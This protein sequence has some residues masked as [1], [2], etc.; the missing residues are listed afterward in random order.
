MQ[1]VVCCEIPVVT[2]GGGGCAGAPACNNNLDEDSTLHNAITN[3]NA[4][5]LNILI[6]D[7]LI[8]LLFCINGFAK[9]FVWLEVRSVRVFYF[10]TPSYPS[11]SNECD[12]NFNRLSKI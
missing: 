9:E 3:A 10:K 2:G 11:N 5:T 4:I 7:Y 8:L 6:L 12:N 1:S